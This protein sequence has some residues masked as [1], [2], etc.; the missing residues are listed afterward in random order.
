MSVKEKYM[1]W[2]II[3]VVL[4]QAGQRTAL[5]H[6]VREALANADTMHVLASYPAST[7]P[8][9]NLRMCLRKP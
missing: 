8:H 7:C 4:A 3:R 5:V 1:T 2:T 9:P 6:E